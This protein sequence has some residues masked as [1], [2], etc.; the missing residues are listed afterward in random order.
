M[1]SAVGPSDTNETELSVS[2]SSTG[3]LPGSLMELVERAVK[4]AVLAELATLNVGPGYRV[5][6]LPRPSGNNTSR[7]AAADTN[8]GIIIIIRP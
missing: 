1:S 2:I 8:I 4:S 5:T 7:V 6:D 3:Q